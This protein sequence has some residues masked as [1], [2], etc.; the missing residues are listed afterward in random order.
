MIVSLYKFF[1]SIIYN[2]NGPVVIAL[3]RKSDAQSSSPTRIL[4][5]NLVCL[6]LAYS[7]LIHVFINPETSPPPF[8]AVACRNLKSKKQKVG[9]TIR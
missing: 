8:P 2:L 9:S 7:S 1:K 3:A 6:G 4:K 5:K